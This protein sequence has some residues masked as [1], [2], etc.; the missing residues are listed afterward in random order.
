MKAL[1]GPLGEN[2]PS[3]VGVDDHTCRINDPL[4]CASRPA[5]DSTDDQVVEVLEGDH[6][7]AFACLPPDAFYGCPDGV[8]YQGPPVS[9][10]QGLN[11]FTPE[12]RID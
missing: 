9:R 10:K 4:Q 1:A 3:Q 2:G 12:H 7:S 5:L 8:G 6:P 11:H